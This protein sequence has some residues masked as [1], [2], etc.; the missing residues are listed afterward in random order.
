MTTTTASY[1]DAPA[2]KLLAVHCA[3]CG[4]PLLDSESV[5]AGIG[6]DCRAKH[7][8]TTPDRTP[9]WAA[10]L[11]TLDG[12]VPVAS[13]NPTTTPQRAANVLVHAIACNPAPAVCNAL[14]LALVQLGYTRLANRITKRVAKLAVRKVQSTLLGAE[15]YV[16]VTPYS[17]AF[18]AALKANCRGARFDRKPK[19]QQSA[20]HV[21]TSQRAALWG[22]LQA[23]YKGATLVTDNGLSTI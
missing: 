4:R 12:L 5:E 11:I 16:V 23:C 2:T 19:G 9:D 13:V 17:E 10:V 18:V 14:V 21:P 8:Y 22:V 6:P 20:W 7:G 15:A 3:C 1:I